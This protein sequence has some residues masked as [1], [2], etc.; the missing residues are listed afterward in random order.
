MIVCMI[1]SSLPSST[2]TTSSPPH[3]SHPHPP[4]SHLISTLTSPHLHPPPPHLTLQPHPSHPHLIHVLQPI[5]RHPQNLPHL[6]F[7]HPPSSPRKS[8]GGGGGEEGGSVS[9]ESKRESLASTAST[10]RGSV[11]EEPPAERYGGCAINLADVK[12]SDM[13]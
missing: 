6:T 12:L 11:G 1:L 5:R 3:L 8:S 4:P 10:G 7:Y 9:E 2:L 13:Q